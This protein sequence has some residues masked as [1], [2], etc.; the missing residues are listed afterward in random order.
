[1]VCGQWSYIVGRLFFCLVVG[2]CLHAAV[3]F[4]TEDMAVASASVRAVCRLMGVMQ[5][6][7]VWH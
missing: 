1:M 6:W 2:G 7:L 5:E 4:L 3:Y